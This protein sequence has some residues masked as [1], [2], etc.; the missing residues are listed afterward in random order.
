MEMRTFIDLYE[1]LRAGPVANATSGAEPIDIEGFLKEDWKGKDKQESLF[2]LFA[3]LGLFQEFAGFIIC[4]GN[5][6]LGD[7]RPSESLRSLMERNLK[8]SGDSSDLTLMTEDGTHII[9]STS[10]NSP[11]KGIVHLD[12]DKIGWFKEKN[13]P[14]GVGFTL[15]IVVPNKENL[16]IKS[17]RAKKTSQYYKEA[18]QKAIKLDWN[19]IS[20]AY[21]RFLFNYRNVPIGDLLAMDA[22]RPFRLRF[23]QQMAVTKALRLMEAGHSRILIGCIPRSG[24]SYIMAGIIMA[25]NIQNCLIVT[26]A[27]NETISQYLEMF[28][29]FQYFRDYKIFHLNA[30]SVGELQALGPKNLVIASKQ[31]LQKKKIPELIAC[32]FTMRF[33]DESHYGGTTQLAKDIVERYSPDAYTFF[34]TAT[35]A[36]PIQS[37]S[38]PTEAQITWDLEDVK[39][40]KGEGGAEAQARLEA[41]HGTICPAGYRDDYLQFPELNFITWHLS[42]EVKSELMELVEGTNY[43]LS[44]DSIFTLAKGKKK[45]ANEHT[46]DALCY[47]IFGNVAGSSTMSMES[48]EDY[49]LARIEKVCD[50]KGSRWFKPG[51]PLIIMCFLPVGLKGN[52]IDAISRAFEERLRKIAKEFDVVSINSKVNGG[53]SAKEIINSAYHSTKNKGKKKGLIVLS[54]RQCTLGVTIPMCDVVILLSN[55]SSFDSIYQTMFRAMTEAPGKK[56]GF[57]IDLNFQRVINVIIDYSMKVRPEIGIKQALGYTVEQRLINLNADEWIDKEFIVDD[58]TERLYTFWS[59][60]VTVSVKQ[61]MRMLD[62]SLDLTAE[63][64]TR[65]DS[66]FSSTKKGEKVKV[67]EVGADVDIPDGV[68]VTSNGTA[69]SA[70]GEKKKVEETQ[71]D[72]MKD[73]IGY[74]VPLFSI[75]TIKTD[76]VTFADMC[77]HIDESPALKEIALTQFQCWWGKDAKSDPKEILALIIE[78]SENYLADN[79]DFAFVV[80]R[81]KELFSMA[82]ADKRELSRL[83]DEH[84]VPH[85]LEKKKN[86]EV[87]TPYSLRQDMLSKIPEELWKGRT[88]MLRNKKTKK[89]R[90]VVTYPKIFEPCAG[91]GGFLIDIVDRLMVGLAKAIPNEDERYKKIVEECLYWGDINPTNVFICRLLLDPEGKYDLKFYEGDT[92]TLDVTAHWGITGFDAVIGNPPYNASQNNTGKRG[93]G[94]SL[95][96]K[97]VV[98]AIINWIIPNGYLSYVHPS[99][100]RKPPSDKSK[101]VNLFELMT[102]QNQMI[103]LE[104]HSIKDGQKVF[105]CGTRYDWYVIQKIQ[106]LNDTIIVDENGICNSI[107]MNN[108][109]WLPN[110][111]VELVERLIS[112]DDANKCNIIF[113]RSN[114]GSDRKW[115]STTKDDI[116]KYPCIHSTPKSGTRYMYSSRND[117]G[118]F[119][120]PKIIFGDSGI[121]DVVVDETGEYGMTQHSMAIVYDDITSFNQIADVIKSDRFKNLLESCMWSNFQI[122]WRLFTYFKR[123]FWEFL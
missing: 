16:D 15:C 98:S 90:T 100:W 37:F 85:E 86:A 102:H 105:N 104:M 13:V 67:E 68:S 64:R 83:I 71:V 22:V 39:L 79:E 35:Y 36:K 66:F 77:K 76:C 91:K 61:M 46:V 60:N 10:K 40:C 57:V 113:N 95:W 59:S 11:D 115:M 21:D 92:L 29:S 34:M 117:N 19:S 6:N 56:A 122:D 121:Y 123:N 69:G 78:M 14:E 26:T 8:D 17:E 72:L 120:I 42:K 112:N 101:F 87:S 47:S 44:L 116:Y 88:V 18:I 111:N 93:G 99:G 84:L 62:I 38:I 107:N 45:F 30:E 81:V 4:E 5:F 119:G 97:F 89:V 103:Y 80:K 73:V 53:E 48:A 118:H 49:F 2:R 50:I 43:G 3:F 55:V 52:P 54:G 106:A 109:M 31:Y 7:I 24:K 75:L 94:D 20:V 110:S 51:A 25:Y 74:V 9:A 108:W 82:G 41:K 114:Y 1:Y 12:I 33:F 32:P 28:Y 23:H 65:L 63:D 70:G 27:P 58:V 96:N